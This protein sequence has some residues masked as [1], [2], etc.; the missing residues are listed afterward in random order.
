MNLSSIHSCFSNTQNSIQSLIF[1]CS[2][3]CVRRRQVHPEIIIPEDLEFVNLGSQRVIRVLHLP[4][5]QSTQTVV[6]ANESSYN[7]LNDEVRKILEVPSEEYWFTRSNRPFKAGDVCDCTS[8]TLVSQG[9]SKAWKD[10]TNSFS[11]K[12]KVSSGNTRSSESNVSGTD[13]VF[14]KFVENFVRVVLDEAY[15]TAL[16]QQKC[17]S[18]ASESQNLIPEN[19]LVWCC[20][21]VRKISASCNGEN[22]LSQ[23]VT[24]AQVH[25]GDIDI[26]E[27]ARINENDSYHSKSDAKA[28]TRS[29]K[30]GIV[31]LSFSGTFSEPDHLASPFIREDQ[32]IHSSE[33]KL[34][35]SSAE[36]RSKFSIC[37]AYVSS[38]AINKFGNSNSKDLVTDEINKS[39]EL[40][41]CF[42]QKVMKDIRNYSLPEDDSANVFNSKIVECSTG[43]IDPSKVSIGDCIDKIIERKTDVDR[44]WHSKIIQKP[45][46]LFLHGAGS[47]ADIW[48]LQL[49]YFSFVGYEV[50]APDMLGHG[51]SSAPDCPSAYTFDRLLQD[52]LQIF[53]RF[54]LQHQKCV[55]IGH[56]Y[57]S[58]F[59]AAVARYRPEQVVQLVLLSSGGPSPLVPSKA[60]FSFPSCIMSFMKPFLMCGF[61][62]FA[63]RTTQLD[64]FAVHEKKRAKMKS[65]VV[66]K[67]LEI[68]EKKLLAYQQRKSNL[69]DEDADFHFLMSL[70]PYLRKVPKQRKMLVRTKLQQIFCD[71]ELH[72]EHGAQHVSSGYTHAAGGSSNQ[73]WESGSTLTVTPQ[74]TPE[75]LASDLFYGPRGK[76]LHPCCTY[77]LPPYVLK[78]VE[79]GQ[80]WVEGDAAFHRRIMVPTLLVHGLKDP[81]ISLVEEC[82]MER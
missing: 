8:G 72:G 58:C 36:E 70:L 2:G 31:N 59:A 75:D 55:I 68:E 53:D 46:L 4:S 81:Y 50:I 9:I 17:S 32:L 6:A 45:S 61:K 15:V 69:L 14:G 23:V 56:S 73:S 30:D 38:E 79:R 51:Y 54:I 20:D 48:S 37:G 7:T 5:Q 19:E 71:E 21:S 66:E 62:S 65:S 10:V 63:K 24:V 44:C 60:V 77:E 13:N 57:G 74:N 43:S 3:A 40:P 64:Q 27:D 22:L 34:E 67:L 39:E 16:S 82:E 80:E 42:D 33:S 35:V 26:I 25:H 49:Q 11:V 76:H 47:S 18:S 28:L 52:V 41:E 29:T 12:V 1:R 78:H